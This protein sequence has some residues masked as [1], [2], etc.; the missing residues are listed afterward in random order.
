[1]DWAED[2]PEHMATPEEAVDEWR[3]IVGAGRADEAWLLHDYD[4]W[5]KNPYYSGPPVPHPE[6]E[7][8]YESVGHTPPP[9]PP[10]H[11][12]PRCPDDSCDANHCPNCGGHKLDWYATGL[13][14]S[15]QQAED[16]IPF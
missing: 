12:S 2:P 14:S 10:P 15:C 16:E 7:A 1:M 11:T 9:L 13:C 6:D 5:V 4:V 8:F 3:F